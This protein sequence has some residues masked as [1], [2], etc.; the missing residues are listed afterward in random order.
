MRKIMDAS[1]PFCAGNAKLS[2]R[3][4]EFYGRNY[5]GAAKVKIGAQ[6][7]CNRCKARGPLFTTTFI[8]DQYPYADNPECD[9]IKD[10]AID[11]WNRGGWMI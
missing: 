3:I 1:C 5:Y 7:I 8:S 10:K 9:E 2:T 11:L 4:V 6:V